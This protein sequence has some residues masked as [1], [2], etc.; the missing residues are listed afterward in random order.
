MEI[1]TLQ[2]EPC[3][4]TR[5]IHTDRPRIATIKSSFTPTRDPPSRSQGSS[6]ALNVALPTAG[7]AVSEVQEAEEEGQ[8]HKT[9]G[10]KL[11][12]LI[13]GGLFAVRKKSALRGILVGVREED[14]VGRLPVHSGTALVDQAAVQRWFLGAF[15]LGAARDAAQSDSKSLGSVNTSTRQT[16]DETSRLTIPAPRRSSPLTASR[17]AT[18]NMGIASMKRAM[19]PMKQVIMPN[20][21]VKVPYFRVVGGPPIW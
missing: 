10:H 4:R 11:K 20:P 5:Q 17:P 18:R 13:Y 12:G 8:Q 3:M 19:I 1:V 16:T 7:P 2:L 15:V 6:Q 21:P 9:A 14:A